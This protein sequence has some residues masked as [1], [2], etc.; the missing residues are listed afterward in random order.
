MHEPAGLPPT[1]RQ[2]P[3]SQCCVFVGGFWLFPKDKTMMKGNYIWSVRT[4]RQSGQHKEERVLPRWVRMRRVCSV[5]RGVFC[6][7]PV[8]LCLLL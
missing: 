6:G 5:P 7:S 4:S 2:A 1:E 3:K 8:A